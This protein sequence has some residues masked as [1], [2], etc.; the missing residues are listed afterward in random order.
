M[1]AHRTRRIT[2]LA[3]SVALA[4]PLGMVVVQPASAAVS[5]DTADMLQAMVAEEK[6]AHDVYTTLGDLYS[7]RTFD[8]IA[9]AES[10]H[11]AA[12]RSLMSVHGV[13]D[14]TVGDAVGD[15]DDPAVQKL[16]DDLVRQGSA[17]LEAAAQVGITIEKLDIADLDE[18]LADNPPADIARVLENLR[19]GSEKHLAA[20]TRLADGDTAAGQGSQAGQG[21]GRGGQGHRGAGTSIMSASGTRDGSCVT[22]Q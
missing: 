22:A 15:F 10:R 1:T 14:P 16:Y 13:S 20:F 5:A 2:A 3:A 11:Q 21:K 18:A 4:V 19:S 12:L 9:N 6:L 8:S 17:S 7:V